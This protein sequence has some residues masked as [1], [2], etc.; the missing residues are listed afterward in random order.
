MKPQPAVE[1][2][3]AVLIIQLNTLLDTLEAADHQTVSSEIDLL[4]V[5]TR[6]YIQSAI[7]CVTNQLGKVTA[8][9]IRQLHKNAGSPTFKE[10]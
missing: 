4:D 9:H 1:K 6:A 8:R 10:L 7:S 3:D 2:N 5:N